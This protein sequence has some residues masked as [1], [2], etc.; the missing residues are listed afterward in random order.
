MLFNHLKSKGIESEAVNDAKHVRQATAI[1][2]D[3][4]L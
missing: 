3:L 1:Y 4:S 2:A